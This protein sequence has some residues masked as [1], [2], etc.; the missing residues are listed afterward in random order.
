MKSTEKGVKGY[1]TNLKNKFSIKGG[2]KEKTDFRK[3]FDKEEY[4]ENESKLY[5]QNKKGSKTKTNI[6]QKIGPN[7]NFPKSEIEFNGQYVQNS[8]YLKTEDVKP[9]EGTT[10]SDKTETSLAC[11][12]Q[13]GR[14][15]GKSASP[16]LNVSD[17]PRKDQEGNAYFELEKEGL[18]YAR[19]EDLDKERNPKINVN[20]GNSSG[21]IGVNRPR[22]LKEVTSLDEKDVQEEER[23]KKM[24][25][26][27][28]D[29][30]KTKGMIKANFKGA[31][32]GDFN[33]IK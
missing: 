22:Q 3:S 14:G 11:K 26:S 9:E 30:G 20:I 4:V 8:I 33:L 13:M 1:K 25:W 17:E 19:S 5:S 27:Q 24:K 29:M 15:L 2:L 16:D 32:S 12:E 28:S 31:K 7:I 18:E 6:Y 10:V 21:N 23:K